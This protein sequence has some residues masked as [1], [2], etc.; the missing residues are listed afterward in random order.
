MSLTVTILGCG[1]SGGVPRLGGGWGLCDP[2]NPKNARRRCSIYLQH[3]GPEQDGITQVLVDTSPDMRVQLLDAHVSRLDAILFTHSH[4]DHVH[5][6]DDARALVIHNHKRIDAYMDADTSAVIQRGFG[7][8]FQT[9]PGS[10]YP[11]LLNEKRIVA[12]EAFAVDGPGG[13]LEA[14]PFRLNHGEI[15]ALGFRFGNFAYTPDLKFI[16]PESL[17]HLEG[18]DVWVID[19]LRRHS[20]P[21]HFSL[22]DALAHI[23]KL[24]PKRAILTN[25]HNDLDYESLCRELPSHIVP[26]YDGMKFGV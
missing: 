3:N 10:L 20:H 21:S 4:A 26:A 5:G 6:M 14:L 22:S 11:S 19:A 2:H 25:L 24:K 18:L 13:P 8:I 9:P 12:G 15:D 1:S 17:Q 23:E 16:P 7:Y